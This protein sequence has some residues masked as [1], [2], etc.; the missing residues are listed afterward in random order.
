MWEKLNL[1]LVILAYAAPVMLLSALI[2]VVI[3]VV[4]QRGMNDI[5]RGM[6][7]RVERKEP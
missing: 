1:A 2:D 3:G 7:D 5:R 6:H 4:V